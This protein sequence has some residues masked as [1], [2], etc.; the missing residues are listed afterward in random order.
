MSTNIDVKKR[1]PP[2]SGYRLYIKKGPVE[3]DPWQL[4]KSKFQL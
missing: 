4:A 1:V 2:L 3:Q